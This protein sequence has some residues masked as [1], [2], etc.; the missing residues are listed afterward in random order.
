ML[1]INNLF[2]TQDIYLST[3]HGT[4]LWYFC[5]SSRFSFA[6]LLLYLYE[7]RIHQ[8]QSEHN[9]HYDAKRLNAI[10]RIRI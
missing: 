7:P 3:F 1:T 8:V 2:R 6:I 4:V 5:C 9:G 10:I